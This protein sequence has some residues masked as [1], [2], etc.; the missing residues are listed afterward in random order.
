MESQSRFES[1]LKKLEKRIKKDGEASQKKLRELS[2]QVFACAADALKGSRNAFYK[3]LS[4][5]KL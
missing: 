3:S 5:M 2:S 1:D 4:T